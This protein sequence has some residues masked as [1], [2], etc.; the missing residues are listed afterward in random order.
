MRILK[1]TATFISFAI[2]ALGALGVFAPEILLALGR[3]LLAPPALYVV[4]VLR[5]TFGALLIAV[6]AETRIPV[7]LRVFGG[8]V[9]AAG[10]V[11]PYFGMERS[12]AIV[13]WLSEDHA[14]MRGIALAPLLLGLLLVYAI[15]SKRK[16]VAAEL[17]R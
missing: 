10:L 6:A 16:A 3:S 17:R 15:N 13:S 1:A 11:T 8:F 2:A 7:T 14:L 9:V 5:V 4:A 12:A